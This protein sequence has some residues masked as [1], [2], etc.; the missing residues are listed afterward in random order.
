VSE[1]TTMLNRLWSRAIV[2]RLAAAGIRD[3]IACS[4]GRSMAFNMELATSN[5]IRTRQRIDERA[6][7]FFALGLARVSGRPVVVLTT[8]GTAVAN[9]IPALAEARAS[10]VPLVLI[11]CDR[12]DAAR[13]G[14]A[15]QTLPHLPLTRA[16]M[17]AQAELGD[18]VADAAALEE[19]MDRTDSL[20]AV[21]RGLGQ[22]VHLN[23]PLAG[24]ISSVDA[25]DPVV[26]DDL[27][28]G[29]SEPPPPRSR[30]RPGPREV[31]TWVDQHGLGPGQ[32]GVIAVGSHPEISLEALEDLA[33]RTGFPLVADA[34][35]GARRAANGGAPITLADV[36]I[37]NPALAMAPPDLVLSAGKPMT[38]PYLEQWLE[39]AG[40]RR[41][42]L[43][44]RRLL[45]VARHPSPL[46]LSTNGLS[47]LAG[48]LAPGDADWSRRFSTL[49]REA[50]ARLPRA[51]ASIGWSDPAVID[52]G[53]RLSGYER[54]F[55]ASSLAIR[56]AN[57]SVAAGHPQQ[58][59]AS[60]GLNGIDG[61]IS[62]FLGTLA[63]RGERGLLIIGD[64]AF[65]HDLPAL[66]TT[67]EP[68]DGTILLV[69]NGGAGLFEAALW[70][71]RPELRA[72][73]HQP[74]RLAASGI[75]D[76]FGLTFRAA[77]DTD[78]LAEAF[79]DLPT[80]GL[81]LVHARLSNTGL[82]TTIP[83]LVRAILTD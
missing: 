23:L 4:G 74:T 13:R 62:T 30:R 76:A 56:V 65:V 37:F 55:V 19:A 61:T 51:M 10:G 54:V 1:S 43:D 78:Q 70:A 12:P 2:A 52:R 77:A 49:E 20:M 73:L 40:D 7:A 81:S 72:A 71:G 53:L 59:D 79:A 31:D 3:A 64:Q 58:I 11:S 9:T 25:D 63:A 5:L 44:H 32:R 17:A 8:S 35:S 69:D 33:Q 41:F 28:P 68:V 6:G 39:R 21:A 16:V 18:P 80:H 75:A 50:R 48:R 46:P 82:A 83:T 38:S 36:L 14:G 24:A 67:P 34:A 15:P 45:G 60:R 47:H 66:E 29:R 27:L 22:P 26:P 42:L 57:L